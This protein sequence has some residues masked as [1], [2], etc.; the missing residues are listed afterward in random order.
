MVNRVPIR[1]LLP[2]RGTGSCSALVGTPRSRCSPC[3]GRSPCWSASGRVHRWTPL[4]GCSGL[5]CAVS[6]LG[7][8]TSSWSWSRKPSSAGTAPVFIGTQDRRIR[9]LEITWPGNTTRRLG[10]PAADRIVTVAPP[11]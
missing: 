10:N 2:G 7:G 4:I 6:G 3:A 11:I 5:R 1:L 8:P 9:L